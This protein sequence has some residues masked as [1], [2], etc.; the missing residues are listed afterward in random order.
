MGLYICGNFPEEIEFNEF[1]Y[2]KLNLKIIDSNGGT[3][4]NNVEQVYGSYY[5]I[6]EKIK[7]KDKQI[8]DLKNRIKKLEYKFIGDKFYDKY[9]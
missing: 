4:I 2:A 7:D 9:R 6:S 5:K 3:L 8:E 1:G